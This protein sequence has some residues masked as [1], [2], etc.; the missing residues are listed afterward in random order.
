[1]VIAM[2]VLMFTVLLLCGAAVMAEFEIISGPRENSSLVCNQTWVAWN[3]NTAPFYDLLL[4]NY[5]WE[6]G[7]NGTLVNTN[8]YYIQVLISSMPM[9]LYVWYFEEGE[10]GTLGRPV[11]CSTPSSGSNVTDEVTDE[12]DRT[13]DLTPLLVVFYISSSLAIIASLIAFIT[14]SLLPRLRTLPGLMIMNLFLSFLL[15]DIMLQVTRGY[16][17]NNSKY[18]VSFVLSNGLLL[19][20]FVWINLAGIEMCRSLYR[21]IRMRIDTRTNQKWVMLAV[22]M[23]IGWGITVIFTIIMLIVEIWGGETL[24]DIL[25]KTGF[26]TFIVPILLSQLVNIGALILT[27]VF[28]VIA[29]RQNRKVR[30]QRISKQKINFVRLF[31]VLLTVIGFV[32]LILFIIL[33]LPTRKVDGLGVNIAY[34]II[35]H[36]QPIFICIAFICT[37]KVFKMCLVRLHLEE[38][39]KWRRSQSQ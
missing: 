38:I 34:V 33:F 21:G 37:P 15:S 30:A 27:S 10:N 24:R 17:Y 29:A 36:T 20:R 26:I 8:E 28:I 1:M 4:R 19:S 22:Y 25:G 13:R 3:N 31:I 35:T 7:I 12:P 16:E 9:I 32:W 14:Y 6:D 39:R 2:M 18:V 5:S 11:T 23:S